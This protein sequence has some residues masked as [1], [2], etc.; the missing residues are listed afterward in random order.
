MRRLGEN[1]G[2]SQ[3]EGV[4][5]GYESGSVVI[6][7]SANGFKLFAEAFTTEAAEELCTRAESDIQRLLDDKN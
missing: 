6:I 3:K 7:P 5:I 1:L 4:R 2:E